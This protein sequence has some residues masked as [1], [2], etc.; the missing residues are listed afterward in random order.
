[1]ATSAQDQEKRERAIKWTATGFTVVALTVLFAFGLITMGKTIRQKS[2][3]V[4]LTERLVK[5]GSFEELDFS[6]QSDWSLLSMEAAPWTGEVAGAI[7]ASDVNPQEG[8]VVVNLWATWCKPCRTELPDMFA[9]AREHRRQGDDIQ[10]VF[11][12]YDEGWDAPRSLFREIVGGMPQSVVMLRDPLANPGGDQPETT[13]WRRMGATG[14]PETFFVKD[15]KVLGKV[16]G[17]INWKHQDIRDYLK[18]LLE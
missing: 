9:L 2:P 17:A 7:P 8:V 5:S 13:L 18:M 10:F 3:L 1:M 16:V 11:V 12:G 6:W 4:R 15:G 14:I